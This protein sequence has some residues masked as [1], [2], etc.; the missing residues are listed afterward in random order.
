MMQQSSQDSSQMN[1]LLPLM[2]MGDEMSSEELMMLQNQENQMDPMMMMMLMGDETSNEELMMLMML[3]NQENQMDPMTLMM[4]LMG[5]RRRELSE[6][7]PL[8]ID[9]TQFCAYTKGEDT[10][11]GDSGS[12]L[13][14]DVDVSTTSHQYVIAGIT[15]FGRGCGTGPGVYTKVSAHKD[16]IMTVHTEAKFHTVEECD[17][18]DYLEG[19]GRPLKEVAEELQMQYCRDVLSQETVFG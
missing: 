8:G 9:D 5:N 7:S 18:N 15:S 12:P 2:L 17:R 19:T 13:L 1:L 10:C 6:E 14:I 11:H 16:W 3:Q 4:M